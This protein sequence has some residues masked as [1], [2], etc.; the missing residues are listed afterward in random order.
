MP[1]PAEKQALLFLAAVIALG[2][3]VRTVRAVLGREPVPEAAQRALGDQLELVVEARDREAARKARPKGG[4]RATGT[5]GAKA[6][7][8]ARPE[9]PI[10]VDRASAAELDRLPRVGPALAGRIVAD[11][12]SCGAFGSLEALQRVR[13]IGPALA[14][15]LEGRVTFSGTP[16]PLCAG[17][18][19]SRRAPP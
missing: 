2:A 5:T 10:D 17:R 3:G 12:D 18:T 1:T 9:P 15:G 8:P 19:G 7:Q 16:R 11:R 4:S 6:A 14:R 13:G